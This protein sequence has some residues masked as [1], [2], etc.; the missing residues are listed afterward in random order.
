MLSAHFVALESSGARKHRVMRG[1]VGNRIHM[2]HRSFRRIFAMR[3]VAQILL[4]HFCRIRYAYIAV[5]SGL[6]S[7]LFQ[8][9]GT[10]TNM[11]AAK[12]SGSPFAKQTV[13]AEHDSGKRTIGWQA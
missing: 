4:V 5:S 10:P 6:E 11:A 7:Y 13:H 8:L 12:W 1:M 9:P 3:L 2:Q